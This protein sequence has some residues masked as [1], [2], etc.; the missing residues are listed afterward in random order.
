MDTYNAIKELRA[1]VDALEETPVTL[2]DTE[3]AALLKDFGV[4]LGDMKA[5]LTQVGERIDAMEAELAEEREP[6]QP[7]DPDKA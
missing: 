4:V 3:V 1:R 7:F 2:P 5:Q 6:P